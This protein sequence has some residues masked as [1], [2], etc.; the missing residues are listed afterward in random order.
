MAS[1]PT[2]RSAEERRREIVEIAIRHFAQ[3]GYNGTSTERR[4]GAEAMPGG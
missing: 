2:R 1:A 4:V 3:N